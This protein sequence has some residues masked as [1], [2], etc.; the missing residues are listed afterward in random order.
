[1]NALAIP[2]ILAITTVPAF[3]LSAE[4]VLAQH[5]R[6][7][8]GNGLKSGDAYTYLICDSS[9]QSCYEAQMSFYYMDTWVIE[10]RIN[11]VYGQHILTKDGIIELDGRVT[12]SVERDKF[13]IDYSKAGDATIPSRNTY[14][15]DNFVDI[16]L[17]SA[18]GEESVKYMYSIR[19]TLFLIGGRINVGDGGTLEHRARLDTGSQWSNQRGTSVMV[20]GTHY[21]YE[22]DSLQYTG[23]V[24]DV[25]YSADSPMMEF[26]V[27]KDMPFPVAG[28]VI[29]SE[30]DELNTDKYITGRFWYR[31]MDTT[32]DG[33]THANDTDV[34]DS[35]QQKSVSAP[36]HDGAASDTEV[37]EPA[38]ITIDNDTA[39]A[40]KS[41]P[42][43]E[44][45]LEILDM[46]VQFIMPANKVEYN[47]ARATISTDDS[48]YNVGDMITITGYTPS[49]SKE[50]ALVTIKDQGTVL[51]VPVT[52]SD[53]RFEV[54]ADS[55]GW[56]P[57]I[58]VA[59]VRHA[60][61]EAQIPFTLYDTVTP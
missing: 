32:R 19:D 42:G 9:I 61:Y 44:R 14:L 16:T 21:G 59:H 37:P 31:L 26:Q 39:G 23:K 3:A 18:H 55:S 22:Y 5:D 40:V 46:L 17:P 28:H 54:V 52:I 27:I 51:T 43:Y 47:A 4:E 57:G 29:P 24:Y 1:M 8:I 20:Y 50:H 41:T 35:M 53:N 45:I 58:L 56:S 34:N 49:S 13:L 48:A 36:V 25:R 33:F 2:I 12:G 15:T 38:S 30:Y 10:T 7:D 11:E 6:W 60:N